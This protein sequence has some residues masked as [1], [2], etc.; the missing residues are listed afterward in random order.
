[1]PEMNAFSR[2]FVNLS[3]RRRAAR[4]FARI[5]SSAPI[6]PAAV[7][8]EIGC[9]SGE[10]AARF[11]EGF[12]PAQYVT[13]DLDPRQLEAAQRTLHRH[14]PSNRPSAVVFRE[15][16]VLHLPFAEAT[17]DVVL[18]F[19]TIHHASPSHHDFSRVPQALAEI[20]RVLRPGGLL[21][22]EDFLHLELIRQWLTDHGYTFVYVRRRWRF[23]TVVARKSSAPPAVTPSSGTGA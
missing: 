10:L 13:T 22:Y 16:D 11:V 3:A 17:Y 15:A 18:A 23:E 4:S 2:F 19:V 21:L 7:C 9:G 14:F 12:Q 1:M 8:L 20:D 5:R 6:P